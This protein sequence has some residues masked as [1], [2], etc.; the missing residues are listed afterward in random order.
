MICK[1]YNFKRHDTAV[2]IQYQVKKTSDNEPKDLTGYTATFSMIEE[3]ANTHK[4]LDQS[5]T[6]PDEPNGHLDYEF[7]AGEVDKSGKYLGAFEVTHTASQKKFTV[8]AEGYIEIVIQDDI[9]E[10]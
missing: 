3:G 7:A 9:N 1:D 2:V 6:I 10:A 5:A 8:P 4:V